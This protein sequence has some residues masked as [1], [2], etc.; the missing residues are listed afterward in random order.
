MLFQQNEAGSHVLLKSNKDTPLFKKTTGFAAWSNP[1]STTCLD[2]PGEQPQA[3]F[4]PAAW[5]ERQLRFLEAENHLARRRTV[6][7]IVYR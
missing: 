3:E 1:A 2:L 5:T 6:T 4:D 7:M